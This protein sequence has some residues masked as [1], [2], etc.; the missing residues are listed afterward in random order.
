VIFRRKTVFWL[1]VPE[2]GRIH[3]R[4]LVPGTGN[5]IDHISI[6]KH[7]AKRVNLKWGEAITS[8]RPHL[9]IHLFQK[10]PHRIDP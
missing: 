9:I 3:N 5:L 6:H 2:D 4:D 7:K 8:P 10:G 1:I